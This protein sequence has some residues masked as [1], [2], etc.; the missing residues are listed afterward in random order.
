[1]DRLLHDEVVMGMML[2]FL[3]KRMVFEE[4]GVLV[5]RKSVLDGLEE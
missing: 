4:Q 3:S 1:M 5:G 2:P